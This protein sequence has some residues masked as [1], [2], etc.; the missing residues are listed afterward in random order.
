[1]HFVPL[2]GSLFYCPLSICNSGKGIQLKSRAMEG[3]KETCQARKMASDVGVET[4]I[5]FHMKVS[6]KKVIQT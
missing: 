3:I 6:V 2:I 4:W 5:Q 1:M